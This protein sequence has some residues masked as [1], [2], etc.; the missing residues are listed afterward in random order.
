MWPDPPDENE[1]VA[2]QEDNQAREEMEE[3]L[4]APRNNFGENSFEGR[5]SESLL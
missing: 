1:L 3:P 4:G 5:T 2:L